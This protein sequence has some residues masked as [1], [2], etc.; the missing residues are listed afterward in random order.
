EFT[1]NLEE[2]L[3][4]ITA[5]E[6]DWHE[7]LDRFWRDFSAAIEETSELRIT[8][9]LDKINEVLEPHLFPPTEDGSDPRLCPNCGQGRLS[10]RTARSG[11]AFIG[12]SNYPECTFTRPLEVPADGEDAAAEAALPRT[13][14]TDPESGLPVSIR[15]GPFGI[16]AQLGEGGDGEKPKR[17]SLPKG[18]DPFTIDL[19]TALKL[20]ALP[21][22]VT[23]Y[24]GNEIK[25]GIGRYGPY[26]FHNGK[27]VNLPED[28]D[29]LTVGANR[30]VDLVSQAKT[31]G[32]GGATAT[33]L[34]ELGEHDGQPV[35]IYSGRYGPYIKY[36][37][38]NV[39]LPKAEEVETVGMD[40]AVE[41]IEAKMAQGGK[42]TGKRKGAAGGA[43]AKKPASG[44]AKAT[45]PNG[46]APAKKGTA[47]KP[48]AKK[49]AAKKAGAAKSAS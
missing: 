46:K 22:V 29:V 48:A 41:L 34:R 25:A 47:K 32:R 28:D 42:G 21:R 13:L 24:E 6:R 36:G 26:L 11:G 38:L 4:D 9:V 35:A 39:T 1:A 49:P 17:V 45:A 27:Y 40:R 37:K 19:E 15:K 16:Y 18:S 43:T 8:E 23:E 33:P 31:R 12:C 30:A 2:E 10:M 3:D 5:G 7:V 20:L 14:G 44:T